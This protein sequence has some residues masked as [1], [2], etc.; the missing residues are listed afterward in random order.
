MNLRREEVAKVVE[1]RVQ[2][3]VMMVVTWGCSCKRSKRGNV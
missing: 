1:A 2:L 3:V